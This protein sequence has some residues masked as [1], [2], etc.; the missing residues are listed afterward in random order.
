M[1]DSSTQKNDKFIFNLPGKGALLITLPDLEVERI[2]TVNL[3]GLKLLLKEREYSEEVQSSLED[4]IRQIL[5]NPESKQISLRAGSGSLERLEP[6]KQ[7][8][9]PREPN[10]PPTQNPKRMVSEDPTQ[11]DWDSLCR[12]FGFEVSDK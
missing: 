7:E 2:E 4:R 1:E 3:K 6:R 12:Y 11:W 5:E 8:E 10:R 9:P